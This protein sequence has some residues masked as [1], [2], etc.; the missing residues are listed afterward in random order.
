MSKRPRL[1]TQIAKLKVEKKTYSFSLNRE[2]TDK[3]IT[4]AK[5]HNLRK[6]ELVDEAIMYYL[7]TI[8]ESPK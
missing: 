6:S 4:L 1:P 7:E 8:K 3:L 5:S 2:N